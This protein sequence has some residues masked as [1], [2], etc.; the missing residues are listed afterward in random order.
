MLIKHGE[1]KQAAKL[2]SFLMLGEEIAQHCA[3][4]QAI[5][6][7]NAV[8]RRFL[9]SQARQEKYHRIIFQRGELMLS[10]KGGNCGS[11]KN[12]LL[13]YKK[14]LDEAT[15]TNNFEETLLG[16]QII[17]EGL[18]E[19]VLEN[20]DHGMSNRK[21]GFHRI[22]HL[23][24]SQ[25]HAHHQFGLRKLDACV[26]NNEVKQQK[27]SSRVYDYMNLIE[28]MLLNLQDLFEYFNYDS[29]QY[30]DEVQNKL[31]AWINIK[32]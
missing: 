31:P 18:G 27:L 12:H 26:E 11:V 13:E 28:K 5:H 1:H 6:S 10:P 16:Q 25:E 17:L 8:T 7:S 2:F 32:Q 14:L 4:Q 3:T 9:K 23:I 22:R 20:I 21:F 29:L 19:T 15:K 24:L 30:I